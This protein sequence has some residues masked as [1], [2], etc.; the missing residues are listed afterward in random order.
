MTVLE[1]RFEQVAEAIDAGDVLLHYE[2]D[3]KFDIVLKEATRTV[4]GKP[5]LVNTIN[6]LQQAINNIP[7]RKSLLHSEGKHG[8]SLQSVI[9][10]QPFVLDSNYDVNRQRLTISVCSKNFPTL[11]TEIGK[12]LS[13]HGFEYKP[14]LKQA[15]LKTTP[16]ASSILSGTSRYSTVLSGI[17]TSAEQQNSNG[18]PS[19]NNTKS[20][21]KRRTIPSIINFTEPDPN[22]F[23]PLP[24][25]TTPSTHN[26]AN[27]DTQETV[28]TNAT[29]ISMSVLQDALAKA[30]EENHKRE[31]DHFKQIFQSE[32][33]TLKQQLSLQQ[34]PPKEP[35]TNSS[36]EEKLDL[37]MQ[38][39][40]LTA[41]TASITNISSPPRKRR[42]QSATPTKQQQSYKL[43]RDEEQYPE[44]TLNWDSDDAEGDV[45]SS[46]DNEN[47]LSGSED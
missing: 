31:L 14:Q 17:I 38:H 6:T 46:Q 45:S 33:A 41:P 29:T 12:A 7:T 9:S 25:R 34:H 44:T 40:N 43:T 47:M 26:D 39:L 3:L 28:H 30:E 4:H 42:D 11:M 27:S 8:L 15:T 35:S 1:S 18:Q 20:P 37:I 32:L 24:P 22:D 13:K 10:K 16:D 23:P 5:L 21:W 2:Y 19:P 36:V